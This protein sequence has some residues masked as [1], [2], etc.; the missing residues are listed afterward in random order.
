M[1]DH[2]IIY[3]YS[4]LAFGLM[5]IFIYQGVINLLIHR[6]RILN[7]ENTFYLVGLSFL[8]AAYSFGIFYLLQDHDPVY[9]L[10]V[11]MAN[12]VSGSLVSFFYIKTMQSF[13]Q[14]KSRKLNVIALLPVLS[15]VGGLVAELLFL[16]TD[17]NLIL[18]PDTPKIDFDNIFMLRVG[19]FNP[20][21]FIKFLSILLVVPSVM[22]LFI[23]LRFMIPRREDYPFLTAGVIL[24]LLVI[25]L[26]GTTAVYDGRFRYLPPLLFLSNLIEILRITYVNQ[27]SFGRR[28][29]DLQN[30]LI[31]SHKL[32]EAGD[33]FARLSHEIANPLYAARSY[34]ELL[35]SKMNQ[36][37]FTPKM[38]KY[39][40]SIEG[41]F[42]HIQDLLSNVKDLTRPTQGRAL[43]P[44]SLNSIIE[45][46]LEMTRIK[47]Y[48]GGV[49]IRLNLGPDYSVSCYR[50]QMVQVLSN[51]INNGIEAVQSHKGWVSVETR[52]DSSEIEVSI[53]DSGPG[54]PEEI[55]E[56]IFEKRFSTKKEKGNGLGLSICQTI[57]ENHQ[58]KIYLDTS[59]ENTRFIIRLPHFLR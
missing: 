3:W 9:N 2:K 7:F 33:Y 15:A 21:G 26:D 32:A 51:L 55:R 25:I 1:E 4:L 47:A 37:E 56:K 40:E 53:T 12:W 10:H 35:L 46:S 18:D 24:S 5:A 14:L 11:L 59:S 27:L 43:E 36:D 45:A 19:G 34:F 8:S 23:F 57:M 20:H 30:D 58:G 6:Q 16:F 49:E 41:Q 54:I 48:H 39:K 22:A 13:L 31:Q 50:D 44:E 52:L 42:S 28:I 38:V 29:S 17:M